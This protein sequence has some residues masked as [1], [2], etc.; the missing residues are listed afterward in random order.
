[1]TLDITPPWKSRGFMT[2]GEQAKKLREFAANPAQRIP[3]GLRSLDELILGPAWGEVFMFLGRSFTGKSL[4]ATNLMWKNPDKAIMFF[5]M[6]MP[7]HQVLQR[8]YS[9]HTDISHREVSR[10]VRTNRLPDSLESQ[11]AD[12]FP[13]H[14]VV[15][16]GGL[17]G[18][19][20]TSYIDQYE[21]Y[22]Q[23]RPDL[24]IV[25]YL[26]LMGGGKASAEGWIRTEATAATLKDWAKS[27][28]IGVAVLHQANRTVTKQWEPPTENSAKGGGYT[29]ADV[30]VGI[31]RPGW[32]PALPAHE[33][34]MQ[35]HDL[36]MNVIK[37]RPNGRLTQSPLEYRI[38]D[39]MRLVPTG[40]TAAKERAVVVPDAV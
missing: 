32:D 11:L 6:E 26:E 36:S 12:A 34:T 13:M 4:I 17:S 37:N 20:M 24:V 35:E 8:L 38:T 28:G 31:Y 30:V 19:D 16:K 5:S 3:T 40:M 29:E 2:L 10:M 25:D 39:S 27:E 21:T 33:R 9:H 7:S 18:G 14:V 15:D 1:M 22:Y 23:R